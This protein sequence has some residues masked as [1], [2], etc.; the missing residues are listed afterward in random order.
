MIE[1]FHEVVDEMDQDF[2]GFEI[3][4]K[5]NGDRPCPAFLISEEE[6]QR[7]SK[8]WKKILIIKLLKRK[9][10]FE[11]LKKK[12]FINYRLGKAF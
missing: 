4:E 10:G 5:M 6:E 7:L 8:P 12:S 2:S 3:I 9:I 11:A 1:N